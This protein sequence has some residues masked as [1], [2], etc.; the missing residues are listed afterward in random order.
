MAE[1]SDTEYEVE[2]LVGRR[3]ADGHFL[4]KWIGYS[5]SD[6]TWEPPDKLPPDMVAAWPGGGS[7]VGK[8]R[9]IGK[10]K[11]RADDGTDAGG[12]TDRGHR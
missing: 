1:A 7:D 10:G 2:R 8:K 11:A 12:P 5:I 3:H 9:A 4:V 6:N